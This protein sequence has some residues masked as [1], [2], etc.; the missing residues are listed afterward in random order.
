M[1]RICCIR[2]VRHRDAGGR[3][4]DL[5]CAQIHRR[6]KGP[7]RAWHNPGTGRLTTF[8]DSVPKDTKLKALR[9]AVQQLVLDW[10]DFMGDWLCGWNLHAGTVRDGQARSS[11]RRIMGSRACIW[12]VRTPVSVIV[13]Q[14]AHGATKKEMLAEYPDP[15]P[16][17]MHQAMEYAAWLTQ[18]EVRV[19]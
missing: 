17:D 4:K 12:S 11:E 13:G 6:G 14:F 7:H 10:K 8:P 15:E 9:S 5:G 18:E 2:A 1:A 19:R 3:L 16:E